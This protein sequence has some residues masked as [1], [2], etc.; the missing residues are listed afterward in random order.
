MES[1]VNGVRHRVSVLSAFANMLPRFTSLVALASVLCSYGGVPVC[2]QK[3]RGM[4]SRYIL[5]R[6]NKRRQVWS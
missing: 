3:G 5:G 1:T 2:C 4:C 6:K